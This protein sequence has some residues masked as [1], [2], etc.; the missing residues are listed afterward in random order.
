M[1]FKSIGQKF[2]K[3]LTAPKSFSRNEW[4]CVAG[5]LLLAY[6]VCHRV[7]TVKIEAEE[8]VGGIPGCVQAAKRRNGSLKC[9][10]CED[11]YRM[12]R[13]KCVDH[14]SR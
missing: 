13:G 7:K 12:R 11:G 2:K 9:V 8:E 5:V 3:I 1:N 14:Q 4:L 6:L 10:Q